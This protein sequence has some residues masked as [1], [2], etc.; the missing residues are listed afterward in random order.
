MNDYETKAASLISWHRKHVFDDNA[1]VADCH[2]RAIRRLKALSGLSK[3]P[4]HTAIRK[5]RGERR[6]D[7][8]WGAAR[9]V[10]CWIYQTAMGT[11]GTKREALASLK[12]P[13]AR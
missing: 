13:L 6:I 7:V 12:S 3:V 8:G 5:Y 1:H 10:R 2:S 11:F 4:A 9:Y